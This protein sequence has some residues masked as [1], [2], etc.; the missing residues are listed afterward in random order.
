MRDYAVISVKQV[1]LIRHLDIYLL[2]S[3]VS[4][5]IVHGSGS[6]RTPPTGSHAAHGNQ[7][8]KL[9]QK[10]HG[11]SFEEAKQV[12]DD[13]LHLSKLDCRFS[14]FEERWITVG[15]T[16]KG[17]ILVVANL[18]FSDSGEEIIRII[19]ARPANQHERNYH[20]KY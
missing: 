10:R 4:T 3:L 15:A 16:Q 7:K 19:S 14:Y 5:T 1:A 13:P 11:V 18:F 8:N 12:F 20:E 2:H 17:H 6:F 9:N